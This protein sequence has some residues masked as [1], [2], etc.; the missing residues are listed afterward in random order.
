VI[1]KL[2]DTAAIARKP[3]IGYLGTQSADD[4]YKNLTIPFLQRLRKA[5]MSRARMLRLN[6]AGRK[7]NTIGCR[8]SRPI[9]S[10]DA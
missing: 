10:A 6:T 4:D 5:A 1:G 7:I 3:V 8:R 2:A 9:S